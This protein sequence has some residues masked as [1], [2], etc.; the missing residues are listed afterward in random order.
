MC[1]LSNEYKAPNIAEED[2]IVY[3]VMLLREG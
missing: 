1:W 2:I 3:K